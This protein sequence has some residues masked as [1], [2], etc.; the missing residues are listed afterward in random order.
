VQDEEVDDS[1]HW[2]VQEGPAVDVLEAYAEAHDQQLV[3]SDEDEVE[4]MR[5]RGEGREL[6][7]WITH[8]GQAHYLDIDSYGIPDFDRFIS[9]YEG[10]TIFRA[11]CMRMHSAAVAGQTHSRPKPIQSRT[12]QQMPSTSIQKATSSS[13]P[14][15]AS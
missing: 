13:T 8:K 10:K 15:A 9:K 2:C 14:M 7:L 4:D 3:I 6:R 1:G 12:I 11:G 5:Y